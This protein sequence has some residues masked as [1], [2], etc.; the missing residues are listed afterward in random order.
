MRF[1]LAQNSVNLPQYEAF[2]KTIYGEIGV[3]S[4]GVAH[5][6]HLTLAKDVDNEGTGVLIQYKRLGFFFFFFLEVIDCFLFF[7]FFV[8]VHVHVDVHVHVHVHVVA[9]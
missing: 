7:I 1:F 4:I 6:S 9:R 2:L 5:V 3:C 8:V